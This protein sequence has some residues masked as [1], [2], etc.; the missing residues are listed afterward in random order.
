[1]KILIYTL[2]IVA[3]LV[4]LVNPAVAMQKEFA[5]QKL[6]FNTCRVTA[7]DTTISGLSKSKLKSLGSPQEWGVIKTVY[8]SGPQW[9]DNVEVKYYVLLKDKKADKNIMLIGSMTYMCIAKGKNHIANIYI[10]PQVLSRYGKVLR[11]RAELWYNS[12]L[13]DAVQ[14]PRTGKKVPWWTRI[15]PT[16]GLLQN[17]FYTPFEHEEQITEELIRL[18]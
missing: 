14:W 15:K 16:T 2:F 13:Q 18:D 1:M 4:L 10:P 5:I 11:I 3:G 8:K 7:Q 6:E 17:R 9:A 12:L